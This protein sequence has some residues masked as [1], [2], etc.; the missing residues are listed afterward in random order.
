ML[1][2][3]VVVLAGLCANRLNVT[4]SGGGRTMASL[5]RLRAIDAGRG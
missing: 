3:V 1:M 4:G 2:V 5:A